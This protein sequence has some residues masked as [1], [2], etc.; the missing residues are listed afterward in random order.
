MANDIAKN[1]CKVQTNFKCVQSI[2]KCFMII[3]WTIAD[4]IAE[5]IAETIAE[6]LLSKFAVVHYTKYLMFSNF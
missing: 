2:H 5:I 3:A 4:K 6:S 1:E